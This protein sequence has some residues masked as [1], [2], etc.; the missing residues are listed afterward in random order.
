MTSNKIALFIPSLHGGGAE[1]VIVSL[2]NGL[3]RRGIPVDLVL[4][5]DVGFYRSQVDP[6]VRVVDLKGKRVLTSFFALA[7]YLRRERPAAML[8]AMNYVNVVAV[9]ARVL[10]RSNTRLVLSEHANLSQAMADTSG[11]ISKVLPWLMKISY[12]SADAIV[13]VSDGV[14]DDLAA[15]LGYARDAVSTRHNPIE[16]DELAIKSR[17]A[18]DHPWF[19]DGEPPVIIGV[20]RLSKE[21]DFP[22][23]IKAFNQLRKTTQC[24]LVILGEGGERLLLESLKDASPYSADILLAGFQENPYNWMHHASVFV[25][26]SRRE[27]FG[28]VLVEAMA[29][30]TPVV[31][32]AC[33][34]GPEEI[35]EQGRWGRLV[36][37][38]EADA[39]ANAIIG[40]LA[41]ASPPD[42]K[43]RAEAFGVTHAVDAYLNVLAPNCSR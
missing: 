43:K 15:T 41:D 25:L 7:E 29:C 17:V 39:L 40:T 4:I 11:L 31:S 6:R 33:P 10:S 22:T 16:I 34:S 42:V 26:S 30:G 32:T 27:G 21:K 9:W 23:L 1:R 38:G 37:V 18:I 36:P 12:R 24:R 14:A 19:A 8:S 13:A 3:A 35:L 28:N 20:G 2:A 5:K